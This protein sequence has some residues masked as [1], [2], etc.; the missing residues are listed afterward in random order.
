MICLIISIKGSFTVSEHIK[1]FGIC[2][3]LN[4]LAG[5]G[6][7]RVFWCFV[8]VFNFALVVKHQDI[9]VWNTI[10]GPKKVLQFP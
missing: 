7:M 8:L 3:K 5:W 1:L 2:L 6:Y 10:S 9:M 4:F